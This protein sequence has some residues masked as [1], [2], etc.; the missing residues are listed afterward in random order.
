MR[1]LGKP[2]QRQNALRSPFSSLW[3][4]R[5]PTMRDLVIL[6]ASAKNGWC[7]QPT[8]EHRRHQKIHEDPPSSQELSL[9]HVTVKNEGI[10]S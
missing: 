2:M 9:D 4:M 7:C 6:A 1:I 3:A 10:Q 5:Q 8:K